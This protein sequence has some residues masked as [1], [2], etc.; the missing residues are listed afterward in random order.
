MGERKG[1]MSQTQLI[2]KHLESGRS[3]TPLEAL[4]SYGCM[5]LGARVWELEKQGY[6]IKHEMVHNNGKH[7]SKYSL[8]MED[9]QL[10]WV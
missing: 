10:S 8:V 5:R 9:K 1:K 6:K 4:Q 7:F 2:L 3:I